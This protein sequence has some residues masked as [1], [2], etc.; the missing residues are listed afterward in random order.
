MTAAGGIGF[1]C[2]GGLSSF[3]FGDGFSSAGKDRFHL[4]V[5]MVFVCRRGLPSF[6]C[7]DGFQLS[8]KAVFAVLVNL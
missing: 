6:A 1:A 5:E 2:L 7:G 3:A 8:V 4:L